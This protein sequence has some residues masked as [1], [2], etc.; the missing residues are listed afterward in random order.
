MGF[1]G[2]NKLMTETKP[3]Y[4][5]SKYRN[6]KT[7]VDGI[8]YDSAKEARRHQELL[9]MERA[10]LIHGLERQKPFVL[11]KSVV[12]D[13]RKKPAIRYFA[14]F[15]YRICV[16]GEYS[17]FVEDTKSPITRKDPLYRAKKHM[18]K[19]FHDIEITE[20]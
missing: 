1:P 17:L 4:K 8:T 7:T 10:G 6:V 15:Y 14:D 18:M 12:L 5:A 3:K 11:V 19:A 9:L 13:G 16:N 2:N 20:V